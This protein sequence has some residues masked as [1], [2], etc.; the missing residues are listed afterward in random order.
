MQCPHN[1][2]TIQIDRYPLNARAEVGRIRGK[3]RA[4]APKI[5]TRQTALH[6]VQGEKPILL[7][8]YAN[9]PGVFKYLSTMASA[10]RYVKARI[11]GV[12]FAAPLLGKVDAPR[13][14]RFG[15][16]QC[17]WCVFTTPRSGERAMIVPP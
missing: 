16:P 12:G 13:T 2:K 9:I 10:V 4:S 5:K 15:I 3:S 14:K 11:V 6:H 1:C 7:K 17:C 8:R